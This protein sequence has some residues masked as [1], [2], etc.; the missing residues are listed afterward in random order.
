[1]R[2]LIAV[3][4][5]YRRDDGVGE[6]LVDALSG[7]LPGVSVSVADG[8]PTQLLDAWDGADLAVVVDAVIC[9]PSTPGRIWRTSLG[10]VAG[11]SAAGG[12]HAL[13]IPD[14]IRL[15]E[16]LDRAPKRLVVFAVEA[17]DLGFGHGLSDAVRAALP[18]LASLV[19]AEFAP[20]AV[21]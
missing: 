12:T 17:Q 5:P 13:G 6:A 2:A 3:G 1:M 18:A 20:T 7:R 10:Q 21:A 8:E 15:A 9:E 4:N 16:V 11:A 14:A 19:M